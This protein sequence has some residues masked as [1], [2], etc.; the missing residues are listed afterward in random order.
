VVPTFP[1]RLV[2]FVIGLASLVGPA[3]A[4]PGL[5]AATSEGAARLSRNQRDGSPALGWRQPQAPS[6]ERVEPGQRPLPFREIARE[7]ATAVAAKSPVRRQRDAAARVVPRRWAF[8]AEPRQ[9][10]RLFANTTECTLS[11]SP[12]TRR[13]WWQ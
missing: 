9:W 13:H 3:S 10:P 6:V 7:A 12:I 8:A 4:T 1:V 2:F 5:A 11:L